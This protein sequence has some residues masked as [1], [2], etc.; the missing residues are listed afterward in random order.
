MKEL[1]LQIA[2]KDTGI[3]I[4]KDNFPSLFKH[5]GVIKSSQDKYNPN[6]VGFGLA[7]VREMCHKMNGN[8]GVDSKFG[9]GSTFWFEIQTQLPFHEKSVL[10]RIQEVDRETIE[11]EFKAEEGHDSYTV[12]G[13]FGRKSIQI[14]QDSQTRG[15]QNVKTPSMGALP[16]NTDQ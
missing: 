10:E 12:S 4:K 9:K 7:I 2:V 6:A 3:G 11:T 1:K 5:F 13:D 8:V 14:V 16:Q 15:L